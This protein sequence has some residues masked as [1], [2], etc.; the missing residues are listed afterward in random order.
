[1]DDEDAREA[2]RRHLERRGELAQ[3][4]PPPT[5]SLT[6]HTLV[7]GRVVRSIESRMERPEKEPGDFGLSDRPV[8]DVLADYRLDPPRDPSQPTMLRLVKRGS[9]AVEPCRRCDGGKVGCPECS[10]RKTVRCDRRIECEVCGGVDSCLNCRSG[11]SDKDSEAGSEAARPAPVRTEKRLTCAECGERGAACRSC[12][13]RGEVDCLE[14]EGTGR[15]DCPRCD[16]AGTVA[17]DDCE[18]T[19][20]FTTWIGGTIGRSPD[21][22]PLRWPEHGLSWWAR[23]RARRNGSW[24]T[25]VLDGR[26]GVASVGELD[27]EAVKGLEPRM[28]KADG[29]VALRATLDVL[30]LVR[31]DVP[32]LPHRVLYAHPAPAAH[33]GA[34][35]YGVFAVP[36][37]QRTVQIAA[38]ALGAL[39]V[40][41]SLWWFL[42]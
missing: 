14:C 2:V 24:R 40:L 26:A 25:A 5:W 13:G 37:R 16:R 19:G 6:R 7:T 31:V 10:G 1:M 3:A 9:E 28:A 39:A 32:L 36:S 23:N 34:T 18:G 4:G 38:A 8:Y 41:A 35:V 30:P 27:D 20:I 12:L 17:H 33:P 29:E 42:S 21:T 11:D 15:R 22:K